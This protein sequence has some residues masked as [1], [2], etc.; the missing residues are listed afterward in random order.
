M[1]TTLR[2][3]GMHCA[4]CKLLIEDVCKD[5]P[6]VQDCVVNVQEGAAHIEHASE[7]DV[8]LIEREISQ[9]GNYRV[10]RV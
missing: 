8:S 6:G 4:S 7:V 5:I 3:D 2:I 10:S 9:L 1:K